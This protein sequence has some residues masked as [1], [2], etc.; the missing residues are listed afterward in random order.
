LQSGLQA[1]MSSIDLSRCVGAAGI[2]AGDGISEPAEATGGSRQSAFGVSI[3]DPQRRTGTDRVVIESQHRGSPCDRSVDQCVFVDRIE[4]IVARGDR[5]AVGY[6]FA[7]GYERICVIVRHVRRHDRVHFHRRRD[8]Q[9]SPNRLSRGVRLALAI[10]ATTV[11]FEFMHANR[12]AKTRG[13]GV[14]QRFDRGLRE[15]ND[16][17]ALL[18]NEMIVMLVAFSE[19]IACEAVAELAL[20][21]DARFGEQSQGSINGRITD[22][23]IALAHAREQVFDRHVI[24]RCDE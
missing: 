16:R 21:G 12:K 20:G 4:G 1:A 19:L 5:G 13:D 23:G 14:L 8:C 24:G 18:A 22:R 2:E 15:L 11:K 6:E 9:S 17:V 7:I 3:A 10:L